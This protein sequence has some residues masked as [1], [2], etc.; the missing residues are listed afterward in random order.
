MPETLIYVASENKDRRHPVCR[1]EPIQALSK[2]NFLFPSQ[3]IQGPS[4]V[5]PTKFIHVL[6]MIFKKDQFGG[7]KSR[8]GGGVYSLAVNAH[9]T[10]HALHHCPDSLSICEV[11]DITTNVLTGCMSKF[12]SHFK[13]LICSSG[14]TSKLGQSHRWQQFV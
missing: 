7:V 14:G 12:V 5:R 9:L 4:S 2:V 3:T 11:A 8:S 10:T 1:N 13:P 6:K